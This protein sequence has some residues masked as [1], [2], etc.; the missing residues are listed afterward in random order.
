M[1]A[2]AGPHAV[3]AQ[4]G[5]QLGCILGDRQVPAVGGTHDHRV[6]GFSDNEPRSREPLPPRKYAGW[7][8]SPEGRCAALR[9]GPSAH[10]SPDSPQP[11]RKRLSGAGWEV[12]TR[13]T[14]AVPLGDPSTV[15]GDRGLGPVPEGGFEGTL[16][17]A[18]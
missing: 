1:Q 2:L 8:G 14:P 16:K 17:G 5:E 15:T 4:L 18:S 11:A 10:P 12:T 9:A 7:R 6:S 3:T 13:R